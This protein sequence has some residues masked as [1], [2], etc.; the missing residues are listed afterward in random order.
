MGLDTVNLH[1]PTTRMLQV[2]R[3]ALARTAA[4]ASCA[5]RPTCVISA[6]MFLYEWLYEWWLGLPWGLPD[7]GDCDDMGA[8]AHA[9]EFASDPYDPDPSLS[10][11]ISELRRRSERR[12][13]L[14]W[15]KTPLST[16]LAS[17]LPRRTRFSSSLLGDRGDER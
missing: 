12:R 8:P 7:R 15:K 17:P 14:G 4:A 16:L 9:L 10:S 1:R 2:R 13:L 5:P 3:E 6:T 11:S